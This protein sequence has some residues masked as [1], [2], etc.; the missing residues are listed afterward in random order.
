VQI[1]TFHALGR[2]IIAEVEGKA[3]SLAPWASDDRAMLMLLQELIEEA[4]HDPATA[5]AMRDFIASYSVPYRSLFDFD[6]EGEYIAYV[7]RYDVRAFNGD[8][9]RSLEE[10]AIANFL[11]M[12]GVPFRYEQRYVRPTATIQH[13]QYRPDFYLPNHELYIEHF[14]LDAQGHAPGHMVGYEEG[15]RWKRDVHRRNG[16]TLLETFSWQKRDGV[17]LQSL[18]DQ[19]NAHGVLLEPISTEILIQRLRDHGVI[20]GLAR[21][22]AMIL[23]HVRSSEIALEE[24]EARAEGIHD[25]ARAR[26][27]VGLFRAIATRYDMRLRQ[28]GYVDSMT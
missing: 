22:V 24:L 28:N 4:A 6:S 3:P 9:V 8:Q 10:L 13:Q 23:N 18:R 15:V 26:A 17:L 7:R 19:L 16:T 11:A 1:R 12:N 21:L 14:A 2:S 20:S 25:A 5:A 27:F